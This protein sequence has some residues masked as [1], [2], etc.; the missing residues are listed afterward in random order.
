MIREILLY[1]HPVL[2]QKCAPVTQFDA[3]L[4]RLLSDLKE[5]MLDARGLGLAAP[6]VGVLLR[7]VTVLKRSEDG[8][9]TLKL[10]NPRIVD[11]RGSEMLQEGCLSLPNYFEKVRRA[12]WVK[13]EA[14]DENGAH[15]ELTEVGKTAHALQHEIEHLDGMVFVDHLS[16]LKRNLARTRFEKEQRRRSKY[17]QKSRTT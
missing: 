14:Q 8:A 10:V 15:L 2:A 3:E 16:Q 6:Q 11:Q 7:A 4:K 5:T 17:P 12:T 13:V 9:Q 1:P